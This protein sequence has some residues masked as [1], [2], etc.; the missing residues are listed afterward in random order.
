M[1]ATCDIILQFYLKGKCNFTLRIATTNPTGVERAD[2][3]LTVL[4][5][6]LIDGVTIQ[7][8]VERSRFVEKPDTKLRV[9][10]PTHARDQLNRYQ[11]ARIEDDDS[12]EDHI[13]DILVDSLE[14]MDKE[15]KIDG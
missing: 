7:A 1:N 2:E 3:I 5:P 6:L 10:L 9:T 11:Q 8:H 14:L 15:G 4:K 12:L 13:S